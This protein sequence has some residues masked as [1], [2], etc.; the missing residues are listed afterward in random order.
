VTPEREL[1]WGLRALLGVLGA[2]ALVA[3]LLV[4]ATELRV[5]YLGAPPLPTVAVALFCVV[6]VIGGI[7]LLRGAVRG[8]IVVRRTRFRS[9]GR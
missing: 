6:V 2:A 7:T 3:G 5:L 8:R 9:R 4:G 1:G